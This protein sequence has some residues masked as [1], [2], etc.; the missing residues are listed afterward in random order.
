MYYV[1]GFLISVKNSIYWYLDL[2][3]IDLASMYAA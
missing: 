3:L 2:A 1:T